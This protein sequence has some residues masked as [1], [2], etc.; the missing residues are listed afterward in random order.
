[1]AMS[2]INRN[3]L[4]I[5]QWNARSAV[6][7]KSSLEKALYEQ[8]IHIALI[9]ETW[10]KPGKFVNFPGYNV[11]REDREDGKA[12]VAI[13]LKT[14][15]Y[16]KENHSYYKIRN[17]QSCA[18][19]V[20]YNENPLNIVSFYNS[21]TNNITSQEWFRF[22]ESFHGSIILGGDSN[23]HHLAWGCSTSDTK[24]RSM[25][26]A[27][28]DAN[29]I[30]LNTGQPTLMR[31]IHHKNVSAID[32]TL[33]SP[34][35]GGLLEWKVLS[36]SMG[37]NHFPIKINS[38]AMTIKS[39]LKKQI[40]KWKIKQADWVK[41][42]TE[43][44]VITRESNP[45]TC[46][47][48]NPYQLFISNLNQAS[49]KSIPPVTHFN[50]N[51]KFRRPWWN[52]ECE[53]LLKERQSKLIIYK[54]SLSSEDFLEYTKSDAKFKKLC[55]KSN[56]K[57]WKSFCNSLNRHVKIKDVWQSIKR[58]KN[59]KTTPS[60]PIQDG[61]WS[62]NLINSL[63]PHYVR[64]DTSISPLPGEDE[65]DDMNRNFNLEEIN[66]CIKSNSNTAP[67]M[68]NIHYQML[69]N[70]PT[71]TTQ[72]LL[73]IFNNIWQSGEVPE[74]W[75]NIIVVPFLKHGKPT[76]NYK[77]YRPISLASCVLK[78]FER[79]VKNRLD[80][81]LEHN[82]LLPTSQ[83][84]FRKSKSV[85]EAQ[86]S[87]VLDI[88]QGFAEQK[89]TLGIFYDIEGAYNAIQI[90][91]LM[92][93]LLKI[94]TPYKIRR[95]IYA[96]ICERFIYLRIN[97]EL[98]GPRTAFLGLGQGDILSCPL[99]SVYTMDLDTSIPPG[100]KIVQYV[101]DFCIYLTRNLPEICENEIKSGIISVEKYMSHNGLSIS[102][103]K[104]E[105][106]I[107][108]RKRRPNISPNITVN[109]YSI[110]LNNKV[111]FLG[112]ILEQKLNWSNHIELVTTK[113]SKYINILKSV[114]NK[115]WGM[116]PQTAL[117]FY[118][119][120]VRSTLD[121]GAIFYVN[122]AQLK[123]A[124]VHTAQSK[125]IRIAMGYLN[126]TP[127]DNMLQ[128]SRE[129]SMKNRAHLLIDRF[130]LKTI[131]IQSETLQK[132]NNF[133]ILHL[134]SKKLKHRPSPPLV[135]SYCNLIA[136]ESNI[137]SCKKPPI[138]LYNY[139]IT[140]TKVER[141]YVELYESAPEHAKGNCFMNE[142][143]QKWPQSHLIFT[144]G[145]KTEESVG[146]AFFDPENKNSGLFKL[147]YFATIF[148][149]EALAILEALKYADSLEKKE[150][151]IVTDSKS[152][153]DKLS[154]TALSNGNPNHLILDIL[155]EY[156]QLKKKEI[157]VRFVWVRA[158][159][160]ITGNETVDTLAKEAAQSPESPYPY[161]IPAQDLRACTD[162]KHELQ[163][164]EIIS[165]TNNNK[166]L[167]Y[168][169][170]F[171]T[172]NKKPW[173]SKTISYRK[174]IVTFNRL[175]C[176]H[177]ICKAYLN[178]INIAPSQ[179]CDECNEREDWEHII[180]C[181]PKYE[182]GRKEL[183]QKVDNLLELPFN[184]STILQSTSCYSHIFKFIRSLKLT[185]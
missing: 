130:V 60:I 78:T 2:L 119:A 61:E 11:I 117:T 172:K 69:S 173:F 151:I 20:T 104:S 83:H 136:F 149:A 114:C 81:W 129:K 73:N 147:H 118:R 68:D 8:N 98:I 170:K 56:R 90:P 108:T 76:D 14:D 167:F 84:G 7:N 37:S 125:A 32:L 113:I 153:L 138:Y 126:S 21:P 115:H 5:L 102:Y 44:N 162:M 27:I 31:S 12:G 26:D 159:S 123:L 25:L 10:F 183:F 134:A 75:K 86:A 168:K 80:W 175:R 62:E 150:I 152:C 100:I 87:L 74:D 146:A 137:F 66:K 116:D 79:M 112:L 33:T 166:G 82:N 178:K 95:I 88:E 179:L 55:K 148:T 143:K 59:K 93:K 133:T 29:L 19:T 182:I 18:V 176:N 91:I 85:V 128:E 180:M 52:A 47:S 185:T 181:C 24:G 169:S 157:S 70:L 177:A 124:K 110:P 46:G 127:I 135:E 9:S 103:P 50:E 58:L 154:N 141:G 132:L 131:S 22:F 164:R 107:F 57:A 17:V 106:V 43:I 96:I 77:S 42:K 92:E 38:E 156:S 155:K 3:K 120:T 45:Q 30:L 1:M 111:R 163:F 67:G 40:R 6:A 94:K 65:N 122:S 142:V 72:H 89:S 49:E 4:N 99:Y 13:F 23:C 64:Q 140:F 160:G 35:L 144:D 139:D 109:E 121:F 184:Y 34:D 41:F 16:Y 28:D 36:D 71:N 145:S 97:N 15:I 54:S 161:P 48:V 165:S 101:D 158:H 51:C 171:S 174:L 39:I 105:A 63:C 53:K